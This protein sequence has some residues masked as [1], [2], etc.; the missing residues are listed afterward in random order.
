MFADKKRKQWIMGGG[1]C[2][3]GR[4][5]V[6]GRALLLMGG[7]VVLQE[8]PGDPLEEPE[9]VREDLPGGGCRGADV[10]PRGPA[11]LET[12]NPGV[13]CWPQKVT[14]GCVAVLGQDR[15]A[16]TAV[17]GILEDGGWVSAEPTDGEDRMNIHLRS[18]RAQDSL[19]MVT[20]RTR[21]RPYRA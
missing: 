21:L 20:A 9:E 4:R 1:E 14:K 10:A 15:V 5:E 17:Q 11:R 16:A 18:E 13:P 3:R 7:E 2:G 6:E 8:D 19:T 12:T